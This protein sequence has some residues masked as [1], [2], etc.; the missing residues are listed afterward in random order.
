MC[1][2][3]LQG[4]TR[5]EDRAFRTGQRWDAVSGRD[6][7]NASPQSKLLRV[8]QEQQI[9]RLGDTKNIKV[10]VRVI[11]ATNQDME[12]PR[13]EPVSGRTCFIGLRSLRSNCPRSGRERRILTTM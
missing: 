6:H 4:P 12:G 5:T 3:H 7:G 9:R 2:E 13:G 11:A 1:R 10:D 8:L